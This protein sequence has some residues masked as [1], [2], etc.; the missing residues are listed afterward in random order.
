MT[1]SVFVK[2]QQARDERP[3][4]CERIL[5]K[6]LSQQKGKEEMSSVKQVSE[7]ATKCHRPFIS[8]YV[9]LWGLANDNKIPNEFELPENSN[10]YFYYL[11]IPWNFHSSWITCTKNVCCLSE[12]EFNW[13]SYNLSGNLKLCGV[14][15]RWLPLN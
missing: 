5:I 4:P 2:H 14:S 9:G 13:K 6:P 10:Q 1:I 7:R 15:P 8:Q 11:Y 12:L 3:V